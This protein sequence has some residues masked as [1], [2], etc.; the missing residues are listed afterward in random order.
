MVG[1]C[2]TR[3]GV[4]R[5]WDSFR[6]RVLPY[7]MSGRLLGRT[8]HSGWL[9]RAAGSRPLPGFLRRLPGGAR[10]SLR[11]CVRSGRGHYFLAKVRRA[12]GDARLLCSAHLRYCRL[13]YRYVRTVYRVRLLVVAAVPPGLPR[14]GLLR[15]VPVPLPRWPFRAWLDAMGRLRVD[16]LATAH[17]L[18]PKLGILRPQRLAGLVGDYRVDG[19]PG[20]DDLHAGP[21]LLS[22]LRRYGASADQ[23]GRLRDLG[24]GPGVSRYRRGA[25]PF[26]SRSRDAWHGGQRLDRVHVPLRGD[27]PHPA[28]HRLRDPATASVGHRLHNQ[29]HAGLRRAHG[30]RRR[31]L[32]ARRR[33]VGA[34]S[35]G[36]WEPDRLP[37]RDRPDGGALPAA[38]HTPA[39]RGQPPYVRGARRALRGALAPRPAPG[40]DPLP[41]RD[42]THRGANGGR[43]LEAPLRRHR[44]GARRSDGDDGD[45]QAGEGPHPVTA[46]LRRATHPAK[47]SRTAGARRPP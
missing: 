45:R 14:R 36:E 1:R 8:G 40:G 26:R 43:S 13:T 3:S 47:G 2:R 24:G 28:L 34:V 35:A 19:F 15:P 21:P 38:P 10:H 46:H 31:P 17:V 27:A 33:G 16:R 29:S 18:V 44:D 5:G 4:L 39:A 22:R 30:Q 11:C 41:R 6:V 9:T 7:R 25:L 32:R 12:Y 37:H 23:M 42:A 20:H